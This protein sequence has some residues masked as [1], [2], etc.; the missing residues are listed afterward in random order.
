MGP[1][2]ILDKSTFQSLSKR[3]HSYLDI[4]FLENLTPILGMEILADLQKEALGSET[5]EETVSKLAEKFGG[6]GPATNVDYR[7]LCAQSLLGYHIPL[8]GQIVPQSA[9]PVHARDGTSGIVID[10]SPLNHAIL[11]W[12]DGKFE[13][14]EQELAGYWRKVTQNLDFDSFRDQLNSKHV[15]LPKVS[16]F[17]EL[18]ETVDSLLAT[19]A[20]EDVWLSWLLG[21]LSLPK[22]LESI[23][24][25]RRKIRQSWLLKDFST[26]AWHCLRAL[27]ML[28]VGTRHKLL[29]WEPTNLLDVQYLY[30]LPFCMVFASNDRLHRNLAPLLI[31]DDQSFVNGEE[32]KAD[33][34]RLADFYEK[35]NDT[36]QKKLRYALA[37]YPSP[38]KDSVVHQL[39]KKHMRPWRPGGGSIITSLSK[40]E[41]KEAIRW[42]EKMFR[43]VEG[44]AYFE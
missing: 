2:V 40:T 35:L 7:T 28:L 24:L 39:W 8:T 44:D 42:A 10:L 18:R 1:I 41:C 9:R 20:H 13:E 15:I 14:F 3:E 17:R 43:E 25:L 38:K 5:A 29:R 37:S 21:Q 26:Y 23:I 4:H 16:N 11:R 31:R 36:K 32:L 30:Y 27:L 22:P 33:L 6:S 12:Q 34:L 19:V